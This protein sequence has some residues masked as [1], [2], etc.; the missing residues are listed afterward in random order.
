M[1]LSPTSKLG[2]LSFKIVFIMFIEKDMKP[3]LLLNHCECRTTYCTCEI[4]MIQMCL[5]LYF[6]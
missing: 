3:V 2:Y 4:L 5:G 6:I 1:H